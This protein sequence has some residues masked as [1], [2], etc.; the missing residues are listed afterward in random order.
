M[1]CIWNVI[2]GETKQTSI[3]DQDKTATALL[4]MVGK[5]VHSEGLREPEE[6]DT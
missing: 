2:Q 1:T 5:T 4:E 6:G 3:L